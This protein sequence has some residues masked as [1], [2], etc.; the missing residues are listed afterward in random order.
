MEETKELQ[1]EVKKTLGFKDYV[2]PQ[3]YK[4]SVYDDKN[5]K[6]V[7]SEKYNSVFN[8][9]T[10]MF[11][12][13][14]ETP[15]IDPK[16]SPVGC[17]ILD[18]ELVSGGE[19]SGCKQKYCYKRN[20]EKNKPLKNMG[21]ENFKKIF[22][23]IPKATNT[24]A[25]GITD[26]SKTQDFFEIMKYTRD[27]GVIPTY[28]TSGSDMTVEYAKKTAELCGAVAVSVHD[29]ETAYNAVKMLGEAG[30][31][32]I[33]FHVVVF[34]GVCDRILSILDD[35]KNDDRLKYIN[36]VVLLRYKPKNT[37][38]EIYKQMKKEDYIKIFNHAKDLNIPIG[39][40]SCNAPMYLDIIKNDKDFK[41][42]SSYVD[43]CESTCFSWY[44]NCDGR[45]YSCSF[46]EN[47]CSGDIDWREGINMYEVNDFVQ[48][49]WNHPKTVKF[50]EAL[51]K[52]GR[53]CPMYNLD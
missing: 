19:C 42:K 28:T 45:A 26:I 46:C 13:W 43:A 4:Y 29:K 44:I 49:V 24:I 33:N 6:I 20:Y 51:I 16:F 12:R 39:M 36:A 9:K 3:G 27:N 22:S 25:F 1:K 7:K 14:G 17:E 34:D 2:T 41:L 18:I 37:T 47:E 35:I 23:K 8:K 38:V 32:Q 30:Q 15:Q 48:D 21:L 50:R 5:I 10:G 31:K 53:K 52:N 40:D 11:L